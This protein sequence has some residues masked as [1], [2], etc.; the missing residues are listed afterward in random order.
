MHVTV[1]D[2]QI[3]QDVIAIQEVRM[4]AACSDPKAKKGDGKRRDRSTLG[5]STKEMRAERDVVAKA[6][7]SPTLSGCGRRI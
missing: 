1:P 4:C 6:L 5:D 3:S 2:L 7:R